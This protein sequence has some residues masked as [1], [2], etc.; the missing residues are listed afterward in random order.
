MASK[1]AD[2]KAI[3]KEIGKKNGAETRAVKAKTKEI[4]ESKSSRPHY[5]NPVLLSYRIARYMTMRDKAEWSNTNGK[6]KGLP[7]TRAGAM[8][9]A[10]IL[11]KGTWEKYQTGENDHIIEDAKERI[12]T[13]HDGSVQ[14]FKIHNVEPEYLPY[15]LYLLGDLDSYIT[16]DESVEA[17]SESLDKDTIQEWAK[18]VYFS[19]IVQRFE[20]LIYAQRE[21]DGYVKGRTFD[22]FALK[23]YGWKDEISVTSRKEVITT[24]DADKLLTDYMNSK[25]LTGR[26]GR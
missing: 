4:K 17:Y 24:E 21:G 19:D 5:S 16:D 13:C 20:I 8:A 26:Q 25:L 1:T 15:T 12:I 18:Q 9:A 10:G 2:Y 11:N 3:Y 23:Q 14:N 6:Q 22:I 7:Y